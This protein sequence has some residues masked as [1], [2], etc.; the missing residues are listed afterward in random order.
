MRPQE[1]IHHVKRGGLFSVVWMIR[2]E[3][4][5]SAA[6][7]MQRDWPALEEN[8]SDSADVFGGRGAPSPTPGKIVAPRKW[9]S[10]FFCW[11]PNRLRFLQKCKFNKG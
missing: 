1:I 2:L 7:Q 3:A 11:M 5:S 9:W 8:T 6:K 4:K 10:N